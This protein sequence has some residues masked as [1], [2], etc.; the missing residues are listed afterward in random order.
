MQ[1]RESPVQARGSSELPGA[2]ARALSEPVWPAEQA[3]LA[4]EFPPLDLQALQAPVKKAR[5]S[6]AS[7]LR[8]SQVQ[9]LPVRESRR[10]WHPV[11]PWAP[12]FRR[13]HPSEERALPVPMSRVTEARQARQQER[14]LVQSLRE[15]HPK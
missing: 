1:A 3:H 13:G 14:R 8:A 6:L 10:A 7:A 12:E 9:A 5:A 2:W 15:D 11:E 4:W